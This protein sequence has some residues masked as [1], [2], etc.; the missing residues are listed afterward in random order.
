MRRKGINY[1]TGFTPFG[2]SSRRSFDPD[3]VRRELQVVAEDL[4][5][6]A[7]RISGG[8]PARLTIAGEHAADA[9]LAVWFSPFPV[10]MT[11]AELLPYFAECAERAERLRDRGA[12]VVLVTG[13]E[14]SLFAKGF[15]PGDDL[16]TRLS[17]MGSP[18]PEMLAQLQDV[19]ERMNA[20]LAEAAATAR[21]HFGGPVTY[22]SGPWEDLDWTPFDLVALDAY[23]DEQNA[24]GFRES[25]RSRVAQGKPF[26]ATEFGCCTYRGAAA[27]GA[28]GW[29]IVDHSADPPRLDGDYVRDEGRLP[30][31]PAGDLRAGGPR[32]RILVHLRWLRAAPPPG[33]A[34]R[35]RHGLLRRGQGAGRRGGHGLL[36]ARLG[37]QAGLPRPRQGLYLLSERRITLL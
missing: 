33:P 1:D 35:P 6:N 25:L 30:A 23:R 22:A 20:F 5:C 29:A 2:E 10:N 3:V 18:T 32:R 21:K 9:G 12:E 14:M 8:D 24:A 15:I 37:A 28:M 34:L 13:C 7:V 16:M 4:H 19:P 27:R 11:A 31:R 26:V 36:G 17:A